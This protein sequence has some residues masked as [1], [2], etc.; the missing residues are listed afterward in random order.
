MRVVVAVVCACGIAFADTSAAEH[1]KQGK[2]FFDAKQYD[3]AIVEYL[4]AYQID[5]RPAHLYNIGRAYRLAGN[6]KLAIEY[7]QKFLDADP[8]N[9]LAKEV[10]DDIVVAT[11]ELAERDAKAETERKRLAVESHVKLARAYGEAGQWSRAGDEHR[12]AF[13]VDADPVHLRDAGDA[14]AKQPDAAKANAAYTEY[15]ERAPGATDADAIRARIAAL[16]KSTAPDKPVIKPPPPP[17]SPATPPP[18]RS[19]RRI[20]ALGVAGAGVVATAIGS[21]Y[22]LSARSKWNDAKDLGCADDGTCPTQQGVDLATDAGHRGTLGTVLFVAGVGLTGA[23]VV[24][25][26]TAPRPERA[27]TVAPLVGPRTGGLI[28]RGSF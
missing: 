2:A 19:K 11:R 20:L 8:T 14:Y 18:P 23:G 4:A 28:V 24:L 16:S 6:A 15:L 27:T 22:G 3:Q 21:V 13:E 9:A 5:K 7:Y 10:R 26:L 17:E 12:A 25:Y 1:Y